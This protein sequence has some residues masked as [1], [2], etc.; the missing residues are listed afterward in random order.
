MDK[1]LILTSNANDAHLINFA[2]KFA[3]KNSQHLVVATTNKTPKQRLPEPVAAQVSRQSLPNKA[4][5]SGSSTYCNERSDLIDLST[6]DVSSFDENQLAVYILK[7]GFTMVM[8]CLE[9]SRLDMQSILNK[10]HCPLMILPEDVT[11]HNIDRVVYL[12]DLRYCQ[13]HILAGLSRLKNSSLL[14]THICQQGLPDLS[15]T[16]GEQ[17]LADAIGC[18]NLSNELFFSHVKETKMQNVTDTLINIMHANMLVCLNRQ[19]HFQQLLG[20]RLPARLPAHIS[21]PLLVYPF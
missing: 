1:I 21:V 6:I 10:L 18:R 4:L 16:Y 20:D 15:L 7:Q 19:F 11:D 2:Q 14:L 13:Q 5:H 17:L 3:S 8:S 9:G 12:T